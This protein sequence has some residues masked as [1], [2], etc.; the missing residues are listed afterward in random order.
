MCD[1]SGFRFP[2]GWPRR[3]AARQPFR[4]GSQG[5]SRSRV[6]RGARR[7]GHHRG[8]GSADVAQAD[9]RRGAAEGRQCN[10]SQQSCAP[11]GGR[12]TLAALLHFAAKLWC[13]Y[14]Q[15]LR[16]APLLIVHDIYLLPI[17]VAIRR[18]LGTPLV[19]DA[20]EDFAVMERDRLPHRLLSVAAELETVLARR[21]GLVIVPGRLRQQRWL[22]AGF[23]RP[24]VLANTGHVGRRERPN[25]PVTETSWDLVYC[26]TLADARRPDLLVEL[27]ERRPDIRIAIAGHG[28]AA[29][30]TARAAEELPNLEF[31]GWAEDPDSLLV[32]ARAVYYGLDPSA[33]YSD[34]ACPNSLYQAILAHRPLIFFC[35]G[36]PALFAEQFRIGLRV[37]P[38][39][40]DISSALDAI[41]AERNEWEFDQAWKAVEAADSGLQYV[42][43]ILTF[44]SASATAT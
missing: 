22:Q 42:N 5:A 24:V 37:R 3:D 11:G 31:M 28:R 14:G 12:R 29:Q 6:A 34:T 20:H 9:G 25:V 44:L 7:E 33:S 30:K 36:E 41:A 26:G 18:L 15:T 35:G 27:A 39:V 1:G 17:A 40:D 19:Y 2:S 16:E 38:T 32:R 4:S 43:A 21:A 8:L 13:G 23:S 10:S